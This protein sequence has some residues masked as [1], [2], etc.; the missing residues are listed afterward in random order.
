MEIFVLI[1]PVVA[2]GWVVGIVGFFRAG[3]ALREVRA[4]RAAKV[5][6]FD[7]AGLAGLGAVYRRFVLPR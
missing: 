1:A 3:E 6:L 2:G 5:F 7:M 4:L